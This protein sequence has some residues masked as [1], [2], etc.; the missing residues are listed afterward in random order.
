VFSERLG[1]RIVHG[2]DRPLT[3]DVGRINGVVSAA[4]HSERHPITGLPSARVIHN[5]GRAD[6]VDRA[7]LHRVAGERRLDAAATERVL[8][9]LGA[10]RALESGSKLAATRRVAEWVAIAGRGG[11]FR[12]RGVSGDGLPAG[13]PAR[14]DAVR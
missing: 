6:T 7:A 8:F 4:A 2:L 12:R 13:R 1:H 10:Q 9:A 5:F 3:G 14:D 11:F